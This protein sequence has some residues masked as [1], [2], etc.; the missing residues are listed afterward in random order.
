MQFFAIIPAAGSSQRMGRPKLLL[1]W[2]GATVIEHVLDAWRASQV[3]HRVLVVHPLDERLAELG[4]R[5]GATVIQPELAPPEMKASVRIALEHVARHFE[6]GEDDAWLLAPADMPTLTSTVIDRLID[7]HRA[8][9]SAGGKIPRTIWAPVADGR[10]GHPVLFPWALA[11][12]VNRLAAGEGI[13]ALCSRFPVGTVEARRAEILE[14]LDSPED[15]D[16]LR[17]GQNG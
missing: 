14:D 1:P 11:A 10:R 6:P 12:E 13:N 17:G 3:T 2:Q 16:R 8:S 4:R 15:Y 5:C 9:V 7:A